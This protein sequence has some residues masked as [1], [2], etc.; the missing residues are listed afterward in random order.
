[1]NRISDCIRNTSLLLLSLFLLDFRH[2]V[3]TMDLM[4]S[5]VIEFANKKINKH[6]TV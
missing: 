1:M 2:L 6:H 4:F 5:C 3:I